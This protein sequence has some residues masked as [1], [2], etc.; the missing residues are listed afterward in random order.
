MNDIVQD[1]ALINS[2]SR[3][4]LTADEVFVFN[5]TLCDND[6]DRDFERFSAKSLEKLGEL[7]LG[8]TGIFDHNMKSEGQSARIFKTWLDMPKG[9]L[10]SDGRPY[11]SL[12]ARAYMVRTENNKSLI[13][14]I[15]G[16][17]KKEVSVG[18]AVEKTVCSICGRDM[19]SPECDHLKGKEYG[20]KKCFGTLENPFDAYE[21][22]FVAVPSQ[23]Q[24]GVTKAYSNSAEDGLKSEIKRQKSYI[25][26]LEKYRDEAKEYREALKS[27]IR[28]YLC[29]LLPEVDTGIFSQCFDAMKASELAEFLNGVKKQKSFLSA[30]E[31]QLS[32]KETVKNNN[33]F[34]I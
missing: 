10:T 20:G 29:V 28:K 23:R 33:A 12:K 5:V 8:K 15:D 17:I 25:E 2:Y 6:I 26:H 3:K 27:E 16:G 11:C 31:V 1:L 4:E 18:C 14:E 32:N 24:A 21:W 9:A 13:E 22:S 34:I 19:K 7:F 30:P